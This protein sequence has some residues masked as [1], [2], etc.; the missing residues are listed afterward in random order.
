MILNDTAIDLYL[1][2]T[3]KGIVDESVDWIIE[4][5]L[6]QEIVSFSTSQGTVSFD[7]DDIEWE[8]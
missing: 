2:A 8:G 3:D 4:K 6:D 1:W 7:I 5:V